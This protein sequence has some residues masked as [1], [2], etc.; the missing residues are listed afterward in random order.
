[1]LCLS[2]AP[3][4]ALLWHGAR[5]GGNGPG[6]LHTSRGKERPL[7]LKAHF[8]FRPLG[9]HSGMAAPSEMLHLSTGLT[10]AFLGHGAHSGS[11][12]STVPLICHSSKVPSSSDH[13][14]KAPTLPPLGHRG[15]REHRPTNS[16]LTRA[17]CP[18]YLP[19]ATRPLMPRRGTGPTPTSL[20][21][22]AHSG[23]GWEAAPPNLASNTHNF[24]P[25]GLLSKP[26]AT[27]AAIL[28][29][30]TLVATC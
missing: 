2:T 6:A 30:S 7:I 21:H 23:F 10:F 1:M 15:T 26:P 13:K 22:D 4:R 17:Q 14:D 3:T 27:T 11:T 29:T 25:V 18:S 8:C 20:G 9:P 19:Q 28:S 12:G 24:A 16:C 5:S